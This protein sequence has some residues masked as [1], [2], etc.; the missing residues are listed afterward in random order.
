[1][2]R[3][4]IVQAWTVPVRRSA[5]AA[6]VSLAFLVAVPAPALTQGPGTVWV[7]LDGQPAG[8]PARVL[9][10]PEPST[11]DQTYLDVT[12]SGSSIDGK[13]ERVLT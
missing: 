7:S 3:G 5:T 4:Q 9:L 1:M 10:D 12:I 8:T 6:A 2:R 13:Y 11:R